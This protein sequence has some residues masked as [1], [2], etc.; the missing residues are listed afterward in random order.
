MHLKTEVEDASTNARA[1]LHFAVF[2]TKAA[3]LRV[4]DDHGEAHAQ[5]AETMQ[6]ENCIA[7]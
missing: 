6:R 1:T 3:T 2:D 7:G 4:I 5:L